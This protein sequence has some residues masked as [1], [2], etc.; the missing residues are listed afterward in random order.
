VQGIVA[1]LAAYARVGTPLAVETL[2][3]AD[4]VV[5]QAG[6]APTPRIPATARERLEEALLA[7]HV[8]DRAPTAVFAEAV[9]YVLT[10]DGPL[11]TVEIHKGIQALHPELCDDKVDRV[12][13][14]K[15]FGKRWKHLVRSAQQH[16]RRSGA[17]ERAQ[18]VWRLTSGPYD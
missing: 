16:L 10:R 14:G 2:A 3:R 9:R 15:R 12:I 11:P 6:V 4:E 18:G 13:A 7:A 5:T 8:G 1:D 17:V